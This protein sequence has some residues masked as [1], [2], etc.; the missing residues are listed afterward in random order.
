MFRVPFNFIA[1]IVFLGNSLVAWGSMKVD[2]DADSPDIHILD[3]SHRLYVD[4]EVPFHE[5]GDASKR[6]ATARAIIFLKKDL[7]DLWKDGKMPKN[8]QDLMDSAIGLGDVHY[9]KIYEKLKASTGDKVRA[10]I[11]EALPD[12]AA[13]LKENFSKV[14]W[15]RPSGLIVETG[16]TGKFRISR[17]NGLSG[18]FAEVVVPYCVHRVRKIPLQEVE[19]DREM[20][21]I[22]KDGGSGILER[23]RNAILTKIYGTPCTENLEVLIS[24][25]QEKEGNDFYNNFYFAEESL[26]RDVRKFMVWIDA[27]VGFGKGVPETRTLGLGG[28][29]SVGLIYGELKRPEDFTGATA[30]VSKTFLLPESVRLRVSNWIL[31]TFPQ[32]SGL[33]GLSWGWQAK[34]GVLYWGDQVFPYF[35]TGPEVGN[36]IRAKTAFSLGSS[37]DSDDVLK[38]GRSLYAEVSDGISAIYNWMRRP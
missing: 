5:M 20:M 24:K 10:A 6:L 32:L 26:V 12:S 3:G 16:A 9:D 38:Y 23:S 18:T 25:I 15:W 36:N 28:K 2:Q 11:E 33:A 31:S 22:L 34:T 17:L 1:I 35:L 21:E 8:L 37:L 14:D 29:F 19:K 30:S 7:A 13:H 4:I 27:P